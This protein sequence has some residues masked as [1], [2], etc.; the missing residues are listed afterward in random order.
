MDRRESEAAP[1]IGARCT[2]TAVY[3]DAFRPE[4]RHTA[5]SKLAGPVGNAFLGS[6]L[7]APVFFEYFVAQSGVVGTRRQSWRFSW[8]LARLE[9]GRARDECFSASSSQVATLVSYGAT[10][11]W[12]LSKVMRAL[13]T[14]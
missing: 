14:N 9:G 11:K 10:P 3:P 7:Q 8:R 13:I 4:V 12:L 5:V 2:G 6:L 1:R